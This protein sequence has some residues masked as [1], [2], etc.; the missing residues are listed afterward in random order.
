MKRYDIRF[1]QSGYEDIVSLQFVIIRQF[2][3]PATAHRYIQGI[4]KEIESLSYAAESYKISN[5]E[6]ILSYGYNARR[7][8]FK[9]VA[10]VYTVHDNIVLI[11]RV[12]PQGR[13]IG[14]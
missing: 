14:L 3:S 6:S 2:K 11:Q 9:R 13:I 4:Y 8:N 7:I 10:I 5:L 1:I 12:I